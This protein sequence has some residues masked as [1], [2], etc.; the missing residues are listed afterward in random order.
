MATRERRAELIARMRPNPV[1]K[2]WVTRL[3][4]GLCPLCGKPPAETF[5]DDISRKEY[6]LSHM[7][8]SCQDDVFCARDDA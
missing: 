2:E 3:E 4:D 6:E 5:K 8:Q 7:C 1:A